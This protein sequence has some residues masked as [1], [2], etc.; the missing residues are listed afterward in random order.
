MSKLESIRYKRGHLEILDQ[1]KI[2]REHLYIDI[3]NTEQG[4]KV[5]CLNFWIEHFWLTSALKSAIIHNLGW[6][7]IRDMNTRGAPAIAITG[8]LALAVELVNMDFDSSSA[9]DQFVTEKLGLARIHVLGY[10]FWRITPS[11]V[12]FWAYLEIIW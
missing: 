11:S 6:K 1:L 8:C 2:P 9:F 12:I 5:K 7:A 3:Q 10:S 4:R